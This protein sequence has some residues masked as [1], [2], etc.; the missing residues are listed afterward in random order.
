MFLFAV[1]CLHRESLVIVHA[2]LLNIRRLLDCGFWYHE[3][4]N[5]KILD[6]VVCVSD[7]PDYVNFWNLVDKGHW[8]GDTLEAISRL[9]GESDIFVDVGCWIGPT[10]LYAATKYSRVFAVEPDTKAFA[11]VTDNI[12]VS[13]VNNV[14]VFNIAISSD[15]RGLTLANHSETGG[16][17]MT[18][19][20]LVGS[21]TPEL[22]IR[23]KSL[24]QLFDD[25]N[26]D[27]RVVMKIDI[28]GHE[29]DL[30]MQRQLYSIACRTSAIL[31]S[32]HPQY[33]ELFAK[34][35]PSKSFMRRLSVVIQ[36]G[37]LP[38]TFK[39]LNF[40]GTSCSL[41]RFY[42]KLVIHGSFASEMLLIPHR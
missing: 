20:L 38:L 13:E 5:V 23:T 9:R 2:G 34:K 17:S 7:D 36:L 27:K 32:L 8:E 15:D 40:N 4:V 39:L 22:S 10:A 28:E 37:L 18:S 41:L 33:L 11:A 19:A 25:C 35:V 1:M 29:F 31:L 30:L 24:L 12:H 42:M 14:E 16:D 6:S 26:I 3:D 21:G